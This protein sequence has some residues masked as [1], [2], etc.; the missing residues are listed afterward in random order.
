MINMDPHLYF[1]VYIIDYIR[2]EVHSNYIN[3]KYGLI[4]FQ[5]VGFYH[6]YNCLRCSVTEKKRIEKMLVLIYHL[7][8]YC[9]L[10]I[11]CKQVL[12][13]FIIYGEFAV[14]KQYIN[15]KRK[16]NEKMLVHIY[17]LYN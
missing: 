6:L 4:S 10:Q 15:D 9:G 2:S 8:N 16:R 3:D 5:S 7:Y 11:W 1:I 14:C 12:V 13:I 17:H